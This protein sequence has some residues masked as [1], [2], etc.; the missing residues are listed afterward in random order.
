MKKILPFHKRFVKFLPYLAL[1][2]L[3]VVFFWKFFLKGLLPIPADIVAGV[4]Y[5]WVDYKWGYAVGVPVKNNLLSDVVSVMYPF[6][7]FA[8]E[9]LK[10]GKFPLW[11]P[12]SF[13]GS[14]LFANF[15][16]GILYPLTFLYFIFPFD[17]A[18]TF[19][20]IIQ[21][22]LMAL[23]TYFFLRNLK[24]TKIS[25]LLGGI[26]FAFSGF[27]IIWLEYNIHGHVAAFIPLFLFLTDK[28]LEDSRWGIGL[29]L[30]IGLQI[31]A[32]YP[33]VTLYSFLLLGF[34]FLYRLLEKKGVRGMVS[35]TSGFFVLLVVLGLALGAVQIFSGL[36]LLNLSQRQFEGLPGGEAVRLLSWPHLITFLAP[37]FFG[38]PATG[39]FWFKG[40]YT[41]MVGY[42]G[43]VSLIFAFIGII[44]SK[45]KKKWFFALVT[46]AFLLYVFPT[47]VS[48][49]A[50]K[51]T[52]LAF[53]SATLTRAFVIINFALAILAALGFEFL[54]K[55][56]LK[57]GMGL[58]KIPL[59]FLV[60][61]I[62]IGGGL[63]LNREMLF[64]YEDIFRGQL[65]G[66]QLIEIWTASLKVSLR[67][68]VLPMAVVFATLIAFLAAEKLP[69]LKKLALIGL[70]MVLVFELFRFGWKYSSF[71]K[72]NLLFP[73][74]PVIE[75]IEQQEKPFR[76]LGGDAIP[77]NMWSAYNFQSPAGYDAVYPLR[78]AKF[79]AAIS[80]PQR[81]SPMGRYG[82]IEQFDNRLIDL[83]NVKYVLALK[84]SESSGIDPS[85][86]VSHKFRLP[87][88]NPVFADKSVQIL[89]NTAVLPRTFMVY[90][91]EVEEE[92]R[93]IIEKLLNP[94]F[95]LREKI[96]LEE[97]IDN[98]LKPGEV[99]QVSYRQKINGESEISVDH[100]GD[101]LLF[102]SD[103]Y[104]PGWKALIDGKETQ[105]YRADLTFRAVFVPEG[106]HAIRFIY[107]PRSFRIGAAISLVSLVF[108]IGIFLYETKSRR[109]T[110]S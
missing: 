17:L 67:N 60:I 47:P 26:I 4:Y 55:N 14:P 28:Y 24:L 76:I 38:N 42:I 85:G 57:P 32:G 12:L 109:R 50:S 81:R 59:F 35:K 65:G 74:T 105:I 22:F 86:S 56:K 39:N 8:I 62:G 43:L 45:E 2:F 92:E 69:K 10:E 3:V 73:K 51:I 88:L 46:A 20:V 9:V 75:F 6:K 58:S 34:Y 82:N 48:Q 72:R 5:P 110:S 103:S 29:S 97:A 11:N 68:L 27:S 64:S 98:S 91:Y 77:M 107:S 106:N 89:E 80:D 13:S 40:D 93:R 66:S 61:L 104:F 54:W 102:V 90:D 25:S 94:D 19:Q 96:I 21:P 100:S 30:A 37:D 41:N 16:S 78:Y 84:Y 83:A 108:L 36:E 18:W 53:G 70:S 15:Q 7:K 1:A 79:L 87:K 63:L 23:F 33:Q 49:V 101:G 95:D 71:S 99:K 52:P 31:L 44:F